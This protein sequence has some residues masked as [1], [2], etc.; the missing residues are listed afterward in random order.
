MRKTT[1]KIYTAGDVIVDE[2]RLISYTG[3]EVDL[4]KMVGDFSITEDLFSN[5]LSGSIVMTDSMNLVKNIPI[6]GNEEL[7]ISFYTP[8][9]DVKPRRI[10]FKIYKV[11]SYVRGQ[12]VANV[13]LRLEFMSPLMA[14]SNEIKLRTV[15]RNSPVHN[16]VNTVYSIMK[17]KDPKL[18][19]ILIDDTYGATTVILT[20]WSPIYTI[21]WLANRAVS[22]SNN[23]ISDFVF[24]Q[25]LDRFN[26]LPISKLKVLSQ[27]AHIK[28]H[29]VGSD[30]MVEI[31]CLSRNFATL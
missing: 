13:L 22:T 25:D 17:E 10:R 24:Y 21:N 6:I 19:D 31:E 15:L 16:M 7:Y 8:G 9:V 26:F 30:Q 23:Q 28:I 4:K 11:S 2:I 27:F 20:N 3:F 1:D 5:C 29:Q 18:P 14:I 12:G